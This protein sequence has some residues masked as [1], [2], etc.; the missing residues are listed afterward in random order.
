MRNGLL[1]V[2]LMV[3][4]AQAP[5]QM[6]GPANPMPAYPMPVV[7]VP[8]AGSSSLSPGAYPVAPVPAWVPP[9]TASPVMVPAVPPRRPKLL[10][11]PPDPKALA[12]ALN[13]PQPELPAPG[14]LVAHPV[15]RPPQ[16][17]LSGAE[18]SSPGQ[19]ATGTP[20]TST[21]S[22]VP[23]PPPA[24]TCPADACSP[25]GCVPGNCLPDCCAPGACPQ[26]CDVVMCRESPPFREPHLPP[27]VPCGYMIYGSAEYLFWWRREPR[28]PP[29]LT[30]GLLGDGTTQILLDSM[31]MIDNNERTGT[32]ATIGCWLD[33]AHTCSLEGTFTYLFERQP[34]LQFDP[35]AFPVQ[36]RPF[37]NA[38]TL[39]EAGYNVNRP[40]VVNGSFRIEENTRFWSAELNLRRSCLHWP[41]V[42]FDLLC[43]Y[44]QWSLDEGLRLQDQNVELAGANAGLVVATSDRFAT[45]NMLYTLQVGAEVEWQLWCLF[46]DIWGKVGLGVN[47]QT[48][49]INGTTLVRQPNGV[50]SAFPAGLLAQRSNIGS[51]DRNQF[52]LA[53]EVG[54]SLGWRITDNLRIFG[55][56][57]L[58]YLSDVVRPGNHIDRVVNPTL[59]LAATNQGVAAGPERPAFFFRDTEWWA[60]GFHGGLQFR[61]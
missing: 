14:R 57:T 53:P 21:A 8:V 6:A 3:T 41:C 16:R 9:W 29:L 19:A 7:P 38:N 46:L 40:G 42:R 55:G 44:R 20:A 36:V 11:W 32:R 28:L 39:T 13:L 12:R 15:Q 35:Q 58:L 17:P 27:G 51:H 24:N 4:A 52:V 1:V 22:I 61:Y 31:E 60:H 37:L 10:G 50:V 47:H 45:R 59:R 23:P 2:V 49:N 56:Y 43:G 33:H 34:A 30:T 25:D 48:V 18:E 5:A 26:P 54:V